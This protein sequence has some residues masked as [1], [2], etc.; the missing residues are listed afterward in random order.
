MMESSDSWIFRSSRR[1]SSRRTRP[2]TTMETGSS[3]FRTSRSSSANSVKRPVPRGATRFRSWSRYQTPPSCGTPH[4]SQKFRRLFR[5]RS[6]CEYHPTHDWEQRVHISL[7]PLPPRTPSDLELV[8]EGV[9]S[10]IAPSISHDHRVLDVHPSAPIRVDRP[11]QQLHPGDIIDMLKRNRNANRRHCEQRNPGR[12][13]RNSG[14]PTARG[15]FQNQPDPHPNAVPI[16]P[17]TGASP[18]QSAHPSTKG[19]FIAL[20]TNGL[21]PSNG[22]SIHTVTPSATVIATRTARLGARL[23]ARAKHVPR[24]T[25]K[26]GNIGIRHQGR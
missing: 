12:S 17:T 9:P 11:R 6:S 7:D 8:T 19:G 16:T 15:E 18:N 20:A 4:S 3:S 10:S 26:N 23:R 2:S 25:D 5:V 21:T 24:N 22:N 13:R 1:R 14:A